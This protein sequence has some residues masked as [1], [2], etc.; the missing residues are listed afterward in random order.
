MRTASAVLGTLVLAT[1]GPVAR[2][3][4]DDPEPEGEKERALVARGAAVLPPGDRPAGIPRLRHRLRRGRRAPGGAQGR[5][6]ARDGARLRAAPGAAP[7]PE[8][9]GPR[10]RAGGA[11]TPPQGGRPAARRRRRGDAESPRLPGP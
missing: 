1:A 11:R 9:R 6:G 8:P 7:Q 2:V 3:A 4:A 10:L 5:R